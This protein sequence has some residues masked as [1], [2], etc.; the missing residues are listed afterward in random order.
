M[1]T[2]KKKYLKKEVFVHKST[3][4]VFQVQEFHT[5]F[6]NQGSKQWLKF[7]STFKG[8]YKGGY[9]LSFNFFGKIFGSEFFFSRLLFGSG[10][11]IRPRLPQISWLFSKRTRTI[12][13]GFCGH[14]SNRREKFSSIT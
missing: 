2:I 13:C 11:G 7:L 1:A 14:I 6:V 3:G 8:G 4:I 10:S 12:L 9:L 5:S